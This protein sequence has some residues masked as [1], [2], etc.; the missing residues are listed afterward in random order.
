MAGEPKPRPTG[1]IAA[2]MILGAVALVGGVGVAAGLAAA[3]AA[4]GACMFAM[5]IAAGMRA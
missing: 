3:V 1:P 4:L 5:A 2:F